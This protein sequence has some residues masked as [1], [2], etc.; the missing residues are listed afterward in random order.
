MPQARIKPCLS[1]LVLSFLKLGASAFGVLGELVGQDL[2]GD[3]VVEVCVLG[4]TDFA[5]PA[6]TELFQN[7]IMGERFSHHREPMLQT[8]PNRP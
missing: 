8:E 6:F 3:L 1:E 5:H 2:D 7:L 4:A